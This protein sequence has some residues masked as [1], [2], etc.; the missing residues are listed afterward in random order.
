MLDPSI[1]EY[2]MLACDGEARFDYP[3]YLDYIAGQDLSTD[4]LKLDDLSKDNVLATDNEDKE[5]SKAKH[6]AFKRQKI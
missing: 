6:V 5:N 2:I 4:R 1:I 3:D